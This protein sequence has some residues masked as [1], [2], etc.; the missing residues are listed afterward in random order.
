MEQQYKYIFEEAV[1]KSALN[2]EGKFDY[3]KLEFKRAGLADC[4]IKEEKEELIFTF[5]LND[6]KPFQEIR[7]EKK[8]KKLLVL[9]DAAGLVNLYKDYFFRLSD[10]NLYYDRNGRVTVLRRDVYERGTAADEQQFITCYKALIGYTLQKRY[11]YEDYLDGG[12]NLMKKDKFLAKIMP[13]ETLEEIVDFLGQEYQEEDIAFREKRMEVERSWYRI[14]RWYLFISLLL[15]VGASAYIMYASFVQRPR[16]DAML[17]ADNAFMESNYVGVIDSLKNVDMQYLDKYKK[18]MLS[19][20]YV[21][22][23]NLTSEQKENILASISIN[24]DE[25]L[26]EYWIYLGRLNTDEAENIALQRSDD[27]LLLYC[28][29]TKRSLLE[30]NT[31][32]SGAEKTALLNDMESK[33]EELAGKYETEE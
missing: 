3:K 15:I 29:L 25:K 5:D 26:K 27:Q 4:I 14:N 20:A 18:Y 31:E 11:K 32:L 9:L 30:K 17:G 13:L 21:K 19:V 28:Y 16:T 7:K 10:D 8:Y 1:K 2:A 6:L 12:M 22:S 23:E 33:I 24:G